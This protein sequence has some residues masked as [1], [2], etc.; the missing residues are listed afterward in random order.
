MVELTRLFATLLVAVVVGPEPGARS[1]AAGS[2]PTQTAHS[3]PSVSPQDASSCSISHPIKGN[4]TTY[5]G[6]RCIY[7][8]PGGQFYNRTKPERC[9]ATGEEAVKDG[10]TRSRR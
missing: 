4:F 5:S 7:H 3:R 6:E 8:V 9:Y 10:C 2:R 1:P